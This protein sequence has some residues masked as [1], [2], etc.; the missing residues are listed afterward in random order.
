MESREKKNRAT[1]GE[2][3]AKMPSH[4]KPP[5]PL[6]DHGWAMYN[7]P[8]KFGNKPRDTDSDEKCCNH[9]CCT[10][11]PKITTEEAIVAIIAEI[12]GNLANI[13]HFFYPVNM[14]DHLLITQQ[15]N[16]EAVR[17][18]VVNGPG[19]GIPWKIEALG[20][21]FANREHAATLILKLPGKTLCITSKSIINTSSAGSTL[22]IPTTLNH[23][24]SISGDDITTIE[25][26]INTGELPLNAV[27]ELRDL[28]RENSIGNECDEWQKN[29]LE[30]LKDEME[31]SQENFDRLIKKM[32][33][34]ALK[35][36]MLNSKTSSYRR[37]LVKAILG[38]RD[39]KSFTKSPQLKELRHELEE[40]LYGRDN[41]RK[42]AYEF[43]N[44]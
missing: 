21:D 10:D 37:G 2:K 22:T 35:L 4:Q 39:S 6:D 8:E 30:I 1:R 27:K 20:F 40:I 12:P 15:V 33:K 38:L 41:L 36:K 11:K 3:E 14:L 29:L 17:E 24:N 31:I 16:Q 5:V 43:Y 26:M 9:S 42:W 32:E 25:N 19:Y 7:F 34:H 28:V 18:G 44:N 23:E 13:T